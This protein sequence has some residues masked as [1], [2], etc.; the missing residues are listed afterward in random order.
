MKKLLITLLVFVPLFVFSGGI[1]K[2]GQLTKGKFD[3]Y[4]TAAGDTIS[5]GDQLFINPPKEM[6]YMFITQGGNRCSTVI[7]GTTVTV[8]KLQT[9]GNATRGFKLH[10]AFAGYGLPCWIDYENALRIGEISK[11]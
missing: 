1:A 7:S 2:H 11:P 6:A 9:F 5:V 4:I 3:K 8:T 10:A